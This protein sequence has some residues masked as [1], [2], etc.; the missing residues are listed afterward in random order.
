MAKLTLKSREMRKLNGILKSPQSARV[1]TRARVLL[2][3][4]EGKKQK[5]VES[6]LKVGHATVWRIKENY[7]KKG[8]DYALEERGRPGQPVKYD[9]R[10]K[11][12]IIAVA[13]TAPPSG[14]KRWSVRLLVEEFKDKKGFETIN[15]EV[16]RLILKKRSETMEKED[17]VHSEN[18]P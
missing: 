8:L 16:V 12:E 15:R 17:V 9:D 13:C 1:N 14:R 6:F 3:L 4:H 18:N 10:K 7:L 11:A 5:D 2:L